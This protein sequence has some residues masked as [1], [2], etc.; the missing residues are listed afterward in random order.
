M[1]TEEELP[2][3]EP[4]PEP[5][6]DPISETP[7]AVWYVRPPSGGQFGPAQGEVMQRWL[8]EGRISADTLVW[9]EGWP[10][11][12]LAKTLFP[13]LG[14]TPAAENP[15]FE[16]PPESAHEATTQITVSDETESFT[17]RRLSARR[18]R[19]TF[20]RAKSIA[21]VVTLI[22]VLVVLAIVLVIVLQGRT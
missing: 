13:K 19:P 9:R 16:L 14:D 7:N 2:Q 1:A 22:S 15:T 4:L 21:A 18:S 12:R 11:W 5:A 20:S 10:D 17:A 6:A 8:A 3:F